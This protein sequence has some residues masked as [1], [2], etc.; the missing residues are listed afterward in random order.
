LN[1]VAGKPT[2]KFRPR[3]SRGLNNVPVWGRDEGREK[4]VRHSALV[5]MS[6][7]PYKVRLKRRRA[8]NHLNN[9]EGAHDSN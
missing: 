9:Q 3:P 6:A 4:G 7:G 8:P 2:T 5:E 1:F